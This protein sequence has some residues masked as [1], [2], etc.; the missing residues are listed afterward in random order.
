MK[1]SR[2]KKSNIFLPLLSGIL[3]ATVS[4]Y[5]QLGLV[6]PLTLLPFFFSLSHTHTF[7]I[8]MKKIVAFS[9]SYYL[10]LFSF[11]ITTKDFLPFSYFISSMLATLAVILLSLWQSLWLCFSLTFGYFFKGRFSRPVAISFLFVL[12]EHFQEHNPLF[13]FAFTKLENSLAFFPYFIQ[14]S[15][16]LGGSFVALLILLTSSLLSVFVTR[17]NPPAV[18]YLSVVGA[19]SIVFLTFTFSAVRINTYDNTGQAIN[20]VII[21][22]SVEGE[23]KYDLTVNDATQNC[24]QLIEGSINHNTDLVLLPET[25]IP[26]YIHKEK[27]FLKLLSLSQ[28][29]N[30][31]IVTGCFSRNDE[32]HYNS[33]VAINPDSTISTTYNKTFLVPFGEYAPFF[34]EL[35]KFRNLS[36]ATENHPLITPLGNFSC[37]VCIES[38]FSDI[39]ASQTKDG[40]EIILISTN[41]SWFGNSRGRNLHFAHSIMRAVE[42]DKHLM[43]SGN[44]G[45]S[46]FI[47]PLGKITT[48]DFSKNEGSIS[49]TVYKN[50]YPSV[51]S[52]VGDVIVIPSLFIFG[53]GLLRGFSSVYKKIIKKG[54]FHKSR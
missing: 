38:I 21:Q 2:I 4:L 40:G 26:E 53:T 29:N 20:G 28:K 14:P 39:T 31:V 45:I 23:E 37:A 12:G 22:T 30:A 51:Y 24:A 52:V 8:Y 36:S 15:A 35:F 7:R 43:R 11:L 25:S 54:I 47:S 9:L 5:N 27:A 44:C 17:T 33:L 16:Y 13:T 42:C 50:P 18:R 19:V 34:K 32:N 10:V 41:D 46:A 48:A 6:I 1:I 49:Q 3:S